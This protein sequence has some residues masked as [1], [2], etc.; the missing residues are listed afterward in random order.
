[1]RSKKSIP[2][3]KFVE[4]FPEISLPVMLTSETASEF[5]K[6]NHPFPPLI[7]EEY[8]R[9]WDP[10]MDELTEFVPCF[11]LPDTGDFTVIVYYEATLLKYGFYIVSYQNDGHIIS[12]KPLNSILITDGKIRNSAAIIDEDWGIKVVAGEQDISEIDYNTENTKMT[13]LEILP[14]GDI[15]YTLDDL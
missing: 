3:N 13:S 4:Y 10:Q 11:R 12:R 5:S 9:E 1:M 7:V 8:C 15:T 14:T 2:F 6:F